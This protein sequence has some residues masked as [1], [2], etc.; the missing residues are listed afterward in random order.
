MKKSPRYSTS[1]LTEFQFEQ[2][3][4]GRVLRKLFGQN[5]GQIYLAVFI[6]GLLSSHNLMQPLF[7]FFGEFRVFR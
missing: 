2:G 6:P 1:H 4:R 7:H 3:S 5:R